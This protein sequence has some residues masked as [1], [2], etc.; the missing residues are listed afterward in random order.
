MASNIEGY[1][2]LTGDHS[3][4]T[5]NLKIDASKIPVNNKRSWQHYTKEKLL[6]LLNQSDMDCNAFSANIGEVGYRLEI[7]GR[8][9]YLISYLSIW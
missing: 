4:V 8:G 7:R 9:E 6:V 5:F 1:K 2:P 3:L